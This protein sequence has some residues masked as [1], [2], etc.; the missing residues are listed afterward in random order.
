MVIEDDPFS[1]SGYR[2][3]GFQSGYRVRGFPI[4]YIPNLVGI[5]KTTL[6]KPAPP[7]LQPYSNI[8]PTPNVYIYHKNKNPKT[9]LA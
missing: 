3:R 2:V 9:L 7:V 6:L 1:R 5:P 4:L 8:N